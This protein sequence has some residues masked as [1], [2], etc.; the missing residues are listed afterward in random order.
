MS[1]PRAESID[2]VVIAV[3]GAEPGEFCASDLG[4]VL[5][6]RQSEV[7]LAV[8]RLTRKG[9][10][11]PRGLRLFNGAEGRTADQFMPGQ[12]RPI[13]ELVQSRPG[14][15]RAEI[16]ATLGMAPK[17]GNLNRALKDLHL[18]GYV[19]HARALWPAKAQAA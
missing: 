1:L 9:L 14:I 8:R 10:L 15:K 11:L 19:A 16:A 2:D 7:R 3:V 12:L 5:G 13:Y 4:K 6:F 18:Y 17:N